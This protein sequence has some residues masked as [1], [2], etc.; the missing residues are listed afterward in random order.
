MCTA[1][2]ITINFNI[3]FARL[4]IME[5][6]LDLP[7]I[8]STVRD[9][10]NY[11]RVS[12][13]LSTLLLVLLFLFVSCNSSNHSNDNNS[14]TVFVT[15]DNGRYQIIKNGKPFLVKGGAGT[16]F[17]PQLAASGGNTISCWDT[18][19]LASVLNEAQRHNVSVIAGLDI[20]GGDSK[21]FYRDEKKAD[22]LYEDYKH[23]II[24]YKDHPAL[25]S[26]T[27]GNE[28]FMPFTISSRGFYKYLNKMIAT[29]HA[30]DPN[31][32]VSTA[33]I[34]L[35]GK[36]LFN[37]RWRVKGIDFISVNTYNSLK[38]LRNRLANRNWLWGG[39]YLVTEWSPMGGFEADNTA[40]QAPIENTSTKKA[41]WFYEFYRNYMPR[42]DRRF[43][44]SL[45]YFWGNRQEYTHTW[46]SIFDENGNA[47]EIKEVMNDCWKDT[48]SDH[49]SV[50]VSYM[51]VDSLGAKDNIFLSPGSSHNASLLLP[52][53]Q[54]TDSLKYS[55]EI[56]REGWFHWGRTW[57]NFSKPLPEKGLLADSSKPN[58]V[59]TA[60][61]KEGPYRIFITV[62]N[63]KG[64]CATA[65]TPFYVVQ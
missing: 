44:G 39:P 12:H 17:I 26:W 32:P 33:V 40:W 31:H 22:Q 49:Q 60:P 46:Y 52:K 24:R 41:E 55:W 59:F 62:F 36:S 2:I 15:K 37:I 3:S 51:L 9:R 57:N 35:Q 11:I 13:S 6:N 50:K 1:R 30:I 18:S 65:N 63:N 20:P 16:D 4:S 42:E 28:L 8:M 34:N 58:T 19:K 10:K 48:Q 29:A 56:L 25:L 38:R 61:T 27:V 5:C 23:I 54:P 43:L 47:T 21:E 14:K 64:Y 7:D 53:D 45:V